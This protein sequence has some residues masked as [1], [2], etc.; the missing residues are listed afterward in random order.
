VN[1]TPFAFVLAVLA[2][3][4]APLPVAPVVTPAAL[5][6]DYTAD[7]YGAA[8]Q[9]TLGE[10]CYAG[11][12]NESFWVGTYSVVNS[13][14]GWVLRVC[15]RHQCVDGLPGPPVYWEARLRF[16]RR[17]RVERKGMVCVSI[18]PPRSK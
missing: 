15:E 7:Y 17:G 8:F 3:A 11:V 10:D 1:P 14:G 13:G 18:Q 12:W 6:G 5:Q 2:G 16:D 4:P 9:F